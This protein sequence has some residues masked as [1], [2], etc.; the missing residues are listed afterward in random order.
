MKSVLINCDIDR[1]T[2]FIA[3]LIKDEDEKREI[4][5]VRNYRVVMGDL[6][7]SFVNRNTGRHV[8]MDRQQKARGGRVSLSL[9]LPNTHYTF[10]CD[11]DH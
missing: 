6:F 11:C 5:G 4:L 3:N 2:E 7:Y 10:V 9:H 1:A 8:H